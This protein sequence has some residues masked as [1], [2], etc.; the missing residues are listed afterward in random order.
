R[1]RPRRGRL[2]STATDAAPGAGPP[3]PAA[4]CRDR[5]AVLRGSVRSGRCRGPGLLGRDR[6][7]PDQLRAGQAAGDRRPARPAGKGVRGMSDLAELLDELAN[8]AKAYGDPERAVRTFRRRRRLAKGAPFAVAIVVLLAVTVTYAS[9][10][11]RH[12]GASTPVM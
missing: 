2:D 7:E 9:L 11:A 12:D 10:P 1:R 3:D 8:E 5:T 6:E 4:T